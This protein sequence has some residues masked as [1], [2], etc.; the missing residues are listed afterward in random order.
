MNKREVGQGAIFR[1]L[2]VKSAAGTENS[3]N[4][5]TGQGT[6]LLCSRESKEAS[7]TE[8]DA[9]ERKIEKREDEDKEGTRGAWRAE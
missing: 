5:N 6:W 2:Q 7:E 1:D 3:Q 4:E 8:A 9:W